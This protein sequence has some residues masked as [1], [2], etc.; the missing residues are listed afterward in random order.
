M[1][2]WLSHNKEWVFSGAGIAAV[3]ALAGF[4]RVLWRGTRPAAQRPPLCNHPVVR[5]GRDVN[6]QF[7]EDAESA[8]V[9]PQTPTEVA[10]SRAAS[11]YLPSQARNGV[12][13]RFSELAEGSIATLP[14]GRDDLVALLEKEFRS[15]PL[16][17]MLDYESLPTPLADGVFAVI[18]KLGNG[19]TVETVS[20]S[21]VS[22]KIWDVWTHLCDG[23]FRA[24]RL[25]F[26]SDAT[27]LFREEEFKRSFEAVGTLLEGVTRYLLATGTE[28]TQDVYQRI[29]KLKNEATAALLAA[30]LAYWQY[31]DGQG[32]GKGLPEAAVK[33]DMAISCVHKILT[34]HAPPQLG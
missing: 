11:I 30:E 17:L 33:L 18:T 7:G 31:A 28:Q 29:H 34:E 22:G 25:P 9:R 16:L 21:P 26:R 27:A 10:A 3:V 6:I 23:Y 4:L 14:V 19:V 1:V 5:A 13:L 15:H 2:N 8:P 24:Y 12:L 20:A 32:R